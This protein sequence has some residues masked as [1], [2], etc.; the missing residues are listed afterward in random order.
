MTGTLQ[1]GEEQ[2][3]VCRLSLQARYVLSQPFSCLI[4]ECR[5]EASI[6]KSPCFFAPI[7]F[8]CQYLNLVRWSHLNP[9]QDENLKADEQRPDLYVRRRAAQRC[10]F[11]SLP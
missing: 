4:K 6:L 9:N 10:R 1:A 2:G 7:V 3:K 8:I 5:Q 11:G